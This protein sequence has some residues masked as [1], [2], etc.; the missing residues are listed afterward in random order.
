MRGVVAVGADV[1]ECI[2]LSIMIT[3]GYIQCGNISLFNRVKKSRFNHRQILVNIIFKHKARVAVSTGNMMR[4][5]R[6]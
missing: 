1:A 3:C 6:L 4:K 5:S 2:V